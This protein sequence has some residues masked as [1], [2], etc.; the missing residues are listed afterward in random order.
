[1][2]V[3]HPTKKRAYSMQ[4]NKKN[5]DNKSNMDKNRSLIK[6]TF[7]SFVFICTLASVIL[8]IFSAYSDRFSPA[9]HSTVPAYFGFM[10]PLFVLI[11]TFFLIY[12]IIRR[13]RQMLIPMVGFL[14]AW[15]A[16]NAY[17]PINFKTKVPTDAIKFMTYNVQHFDLYTPRNGTQVNPIIQYILD[18]DADI[19]CLQEY[20]Y[21][22]IDDK[23]AIHPDFMEKYPYCNADDVINVNNYKYNGLACLSKYPIVEARRVPYI[24]K[25]NGSALFKIDVNGKIITIINNHLETNRITAHDKD[26]YNRAMDAIEDKGVKKTVKTLAGIARKR[27]GIAFKIRANQANLVAEEINNADGYI[28]ACGDFNDTPVSYARYKIKG[29]K[30]RDAFAD[31]GLGMS[32]TYNENRFFF[33]IDHILYTPNLTARNCYVDDKEK[34]SDHYPLICHFTFKE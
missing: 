19:V 1:M 28:I 18:L 20:A 11:N 21:L 7:G 33:R 2:N 25:S 8:L 10:F 32:H 6:K 5:K 34:Y 24:S 29:D 12:W 22:Y 15:P 26:Q 27:L 13:K 16:L 30:L 3:F 14:I 9:E 31:T 4:V 23:A 17:F